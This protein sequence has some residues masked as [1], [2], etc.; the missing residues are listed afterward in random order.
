MH[1]NDKLLSIHIPN[2]EIETDP[3][4]KK[5]TLSFPTDITDT[6]TAIFS[7]PTAMAGGRHFSKAKQE[8][9]KK[10]YMKYKTRYL[11]I[12]NE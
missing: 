7:P 2:P 9:Y 8:Y 10:K 4:F 5:P 11:S 6:Y 12:K 3:V 1:R